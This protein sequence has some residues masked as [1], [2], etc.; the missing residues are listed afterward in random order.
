[1]LPTSRIDSGFDIAV[2]G[3][4]IA[5]LL[6]ASELAREHAVVLVEEKDQIP[7]TKYWLT[8]EGSARQNPDLAGAIDSHYE[9]LDF[10]AYDTTTFRCRGTYPLWNTDRLVGGLA[11]TIE[12]RGG[13]ILTG[14][15]FYGFKYER[16]SL[17]VF[18]N[19]R[20]YRV[21]LTVDCLGFGSPTIY[22]KGIVDVIGY[23]LLYGGSYP[24]M[25]SCDP[26]GLHNLVLSSQPAYVEAFPASGGLLHLILILPTRTVGKPASLREAFSFLVNRSPYSRILAQPASPEG[27]LGGVVPVGRLRRPALDRMF[28]FGEAG[29]FNPAASATAL[30]RLLYTYRQ[31]AARL[32][33]RISAG[34]LSASDLAQARIAPAS[35]LNERIQRALFRDILDWSSDYFATVIAELERTGDSKLINDLMFGNVSLGGTLTR[36]RLANLVTSRSRFLV[37]T[38]LRGLLPGSA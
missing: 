11:R 23:Y 36:S 1:M 14:H 6:I 22:A 27:F 10:I 30:T 28:F 4:G 5:G 17:L 31:T 8:D 2:L 26:V 7:K 35:P 20:S 25:G 9:S 18:T 21:K 19:D 3:G 29:Q 16:N 13:K 15:T 37:K 12:E 38:F 32:S 33:E 24:A 34:R